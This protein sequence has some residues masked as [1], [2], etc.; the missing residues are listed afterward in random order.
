MQQT[1]PSKPRRP[2]QLNVVV[3]DPLFVAIAHHAISQRE[4]LN[5]VV[6]R[7]LAEYLAREEAQASASR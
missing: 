3:P 5:A 7:A 6:A 2:R 4:R 1:A